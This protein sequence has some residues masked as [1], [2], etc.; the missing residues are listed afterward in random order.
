VVPGRRAALRRAMNAQ[1]LILGH[2]EAYN[3]VDVD[4]LLSAELA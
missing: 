2:I 1:E 3:A 4:A